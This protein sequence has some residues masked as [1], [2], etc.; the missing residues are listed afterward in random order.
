MNKKTVLLIILLCGFSWANLFAMDMSVGFDQWTRI[1]NTKNTAIIAP[2]ADISFNIYPA[3]MW[4]ISLGLMAGRYFGTVLAG[5]LYAN[6]YFEPIKDAYWQPGIGAG[7]AGGYIDQ[8]FS[9]TSSTDYI[10]PYKLGFAFQIHLI[11]FRFKT[12]WGYFSALEVALGSDFS[13]FFIKNHMDLRL[14]EFTI[15]L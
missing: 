1:E 3:D 10:V 2:G 14:L 15:K 4:E 11:P 13:A 6:Y 8:I 9:T 5:S 12:D 7:F